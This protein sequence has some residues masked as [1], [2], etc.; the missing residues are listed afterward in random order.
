MT[1]TPDEPNIVGQ[2]RAV[3]Q[4]Q[5]HLEVAETAVPGLFSIRSTYDPNRMI[6]ATARQIKA[7]ADTAATPRTEV[8]QLISAGLRDGPDSGR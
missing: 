8:G 7:L 3:D 4:S 5:H 1:P 6:H 2:W